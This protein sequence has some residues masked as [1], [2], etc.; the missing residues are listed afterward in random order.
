LAEQIIQDNI[1]TD[2]IVRIWRPNPY[3]RT[4]PFPTSSKD[5]HWCKREAAD[6][7]PWQEMHGAADEW[8]EI[9]HTKTSTEQMIAWWESV[10]QILWERRDDLKLCKAYLYVLANQV[11]LEVWGR[12]LSGRR[13]DDLSR[14]VPGKTN[15]PPDEDW[16]QRKRPYL[17][18]V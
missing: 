9:L 12:K 16:F 13:L 14:L 3:D 1:G 8:I 2:K 10:S 17:R 5:C 4:P 18:L 6:K 15:V 11:S 7:E